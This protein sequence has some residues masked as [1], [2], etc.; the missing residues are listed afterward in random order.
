MVNLAPVD[1]TTNDPSY[2]TSLGLQWNIDDDEF[3]IKTEYKDRPKTKRGFLGQ[4]M[5]PYDPIGMASPAMLACKLLQRR[6]FPPKDQDPHNTQTLDWDDPI[7]TVFHREWNQMINTIQEVQSLTMPRPFY[8]KNQGT[9]KEQ[10]LFAFA[11]AYDLALCYV[12]YLRT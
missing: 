11:D 5:S 9:P 1:P 3:S 10:Q 4:V 12:I 2:G 6:I 7:P 8:P